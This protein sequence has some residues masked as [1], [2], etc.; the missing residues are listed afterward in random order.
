M[1]HRLDPNLG[2]VRGPVAVH[3]AETGLLQG[4]PASY[5]WQGS[6]TSQFKQSG[7]VVAP[8]VAA[9]V[10]AGALNLPHTLSGSRGSATHDQPV[11]DGGEPA[12]LMN[13]GV[14]AVRVE[15]A[16]RFKS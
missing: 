8:P 4:F 1:P 13:L 9:A 2:A 16:S 3:P 14:R 5:P 12:K 7:D 6:R 15:S 11:S 10:L